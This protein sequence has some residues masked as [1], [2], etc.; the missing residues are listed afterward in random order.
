MTKRSRSS[1]GRRATATTR[2]RRR[3]TAST[4]RRSGSWI[5]RQTRRLRPHTTECPI[6]IT[7]FETLVP[8]G[9]RAPHAKH[10]GQ[11]ALQR[12]NRQVKRQVVKE[13]QTKF[14]PSHIQPQNDFYSYINYRWL[15]NVHLEKQQE[16]IVQVDDFRLTQ[17]AVYRQLDALIRDH[18]A[19]HAATQPAARHMRA[20]YESVRGGNPKPH[21]RQA[22]LRHIAELDAWRA[23]V[24]AGGADAPTWCD[25]LGRWNQ[26]E[27]LAPFLPLTWSLQPDDKRHGVFGATL[28]L[29]QTSLLD[30]NVYFDDPSDSRADREYKRHYRARFQKYVR[31]LFRVVLGRDHPEC[32]PSVGAD[33]YA[34]EQEI[35]AALG[36]TDVTRH[37]SKKRAAGSYFRISATALERD[38]EIPWTQ[39]AHALGFGTGPHPAPVPDAVVTSSP[40]FLKCGARLL[41]ERAHLPA[42]RAYWIFLRLQNLAR[43][44]HDW[45]KVVFEFRGR[46]ERGQERMNES[47]AVS[48][49]LYM[50]VPFNTFLTEQY[51]AHHQD[52]RAVEY[53]R[54]LCN[55]LKVVMMRMVT[56]NTWL[57]PA[58]RAYALKKLRACQ[59]VLGSPH[60][61]Q[62][63]PDLAYGP[64]LAD[65]L[66]KIHA[67]RHARA[68]RLVGHPSVDI[69]EM[70]WT[71]YPAKMAGQQAYIVNASYTPSTN[72]VYI[73]Q[74]YIQ[75]PFVDLGDRGIEYNLAHVGFTVAHEL[76]HC[77]DDWG[78]QY[79][80][81]GNLLDWWTPEDKRR[82]KAIQADVIRQYAEFAKRD[83]INFD[84]SIGIG[85]D[86]ADIQGLAVCAEYLLDYQE[87]NSDILP[88]RNLSFDAFFTFFAHQQRQLVRPKALRAQLKTNP[89]PLDKY[90]CNVPLSRNEIFRALY[91]VRARDGM[92]W[93]TTNN[94]W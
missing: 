65:N 8:P 6:G 70:D 43:I 54:V 74:G 85:E 30:I 40:D 36:C 83:G 34:V 9:A 66:D 94:V 78:S 80:A 1:R 7:A 33:V 20:F 56:R 76:G 55:D 64:V 52:P 57:S 41:R 77:L 62:R 51:L 27:M 29:G 5:A 18:I 31:Q 24:D 28:G 50:S 17:D 39:Y 21:S 16:Y 60:E 82:Y 23:Q 73:N 14:A 48:A 22:A 93:H 3:P 46:F 38:Y 4:R 2:R 11:A 69:P 68:L 42:W 35:M 25:L 44:T 84:A 88:I 75:P 79:G 72:T 63:D 26:D 37:W 91:N 67:W 71:A 47:H 10:D 53:V 92:W 15:Q 87:K 13:L 32:R 19:Q 49:A 58:T 59:F 90:R 89:H 61:L 45:E 81:D 86:L 12:T